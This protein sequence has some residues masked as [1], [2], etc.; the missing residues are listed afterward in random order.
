MTR[1]LLLVGSL[2]PRTTSVS[3]VSMMGG[4]SFHGGLVAQASLWIFFAVI[5]L[6]ICLAL[7]RIGSAS[8]LA[9][10]S[11]RP[12]V[13]VCVGWSG[14]AS[15]FMTNSIICCFWR[16]WSG[17]SSQSTCRAARLVPRSAPE[18]MVSALHW[19]VSSTLFW[20]AEALS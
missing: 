19:I 14:M 8:S 18:A 11:F 5:S 3:V 7:T 6:L 9:V 4:C 13:M 16:R 10:F 1:V 15:I 20:A 12:T 2:S 17:I